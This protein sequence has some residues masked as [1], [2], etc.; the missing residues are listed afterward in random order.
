MSRKRGTPDDPTSRLAL[1]IE[2]TSLIRTV[3]DET[4]SPREAT[5]LYMRWG[6]KD[7]EPKTLDEIGRAMG[8][9]RERIRQIER[10]SMDKLRKTSTSLAVTDGEALVGV[11]DAR[12][13]LADLSALN[14]DE[15][16]V[17]CPQCKR[18]WYNPP[19]GGRRRIYCSNK[20]RQTAYRARVRAASGASTAG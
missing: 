5:V 20:C 3:I 4:L 1:G 17:R 11:V 7:G 15:S 18:R 10:K 13:T 2:G 14:S 6:L 12:L 19:T 16:I 8:V 9:T